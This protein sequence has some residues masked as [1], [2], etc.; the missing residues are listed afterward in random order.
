MDST[1]AYNNYY[2]QGKHQSEKIFREAAKRNRWSLN[3]L[4]PTTIVGT[5]DSKRPSGSKVGLYQVARLFYS[6]CLKNLNKNHLTLCCGQGELNLV[7]IDQVVDKMIKIYQ[8]SNSEAEIKSYFVSGSNV[9]IINI[10]SSF[11]EIFVLEFSTVNE[12][13]KVPE[14]DVKINQRLE[15]F[16]PY[17]FEYNRKNFVGENLTDNNYIHDIDALNLIE[18]SRLELANDPPNGLY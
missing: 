3:V 10:L 1:P 2:E 17:T 18:A 5:R 16:I 14:E 12:M 13:H 4:R 8:N 15:F 9:A 11:S 7:Y 6:E